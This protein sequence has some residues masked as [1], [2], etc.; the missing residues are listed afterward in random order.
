MLTVGWDSMSLNTDSEGNVDL[1]SRTYGGIFSSSRLFEVEKRPKTP[2]FAST[3]EFSHGGATCTTYYGN[4]WFFASVHPDANDAITIFI[5]EI[6]SKW[7]NFGVHGRSH[8]HLALLRQRK[9]GYSP[10]FNSAGGVRL[11][12]SS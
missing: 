4:L 5:N 9:K 12:A 10:Q 2:S 3:F 6:D 11:C 8:H 1:Y 7:S